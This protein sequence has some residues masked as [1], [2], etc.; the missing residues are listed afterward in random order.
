VPLEHELKSLVIDTSAGLV[1]A[2]IPGDR[3]LALRAVKSCIPT[4]QAH[5]ADLAALNL[6]PGTVHPFHER[7]W[8]LRHLVSREVFALDWVTTNAGDLTT[9]VIFAPT[10]LLSTRH[11]T[12]GEFCRVR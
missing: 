9:F 5:L 1:V 8:Q 10:L 4:P 12:V 3:R 11:V 7:L 2:H 6:V